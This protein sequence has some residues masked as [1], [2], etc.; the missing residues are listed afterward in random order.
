MADL[1]RMPRLKNLTR[2]FGSREQSRMP[3]LA[4]LEGADQFEVFLILLSR[5]RQGRPSQECVLSM[6][7][8]LFPCSSES[9]ISTDERFESTKLTLCMVLPMNRRKAV[10]IS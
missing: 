5:L 8:I 3:G 9:D 6:T 4:T 1:N 2:V 10:I 7:T